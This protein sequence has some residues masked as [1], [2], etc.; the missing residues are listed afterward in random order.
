[1][2]LDQV[3]RL[4]GEHS[5]HTSKGNQRRL[6]NLTSATC[7]KATLVTQIAAMT[8]SNWPNSLQTV[9]Y[10]GTDRHDIV[11]FTYVLYMSTYKCIGV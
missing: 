10:D 6:R 1:M 2:T 5:T 4:R 11:C 7:A 3:S 8:G 9:D